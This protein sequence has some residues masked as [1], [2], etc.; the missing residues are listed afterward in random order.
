[1]LF[2]SST[3]VRSDIGAD[4][5][6]FEGQLTAQGENFRLMDNVK[7]MSRTNVVLA[8]GSKMSHY[9]SNSGNTSA[10]TTKIGS[11]AT[12]AKDSELG[13]G[14]DSYEVGYNGTDATYAGVLKAKTVTKQGA[15]IWTITNGGSTSAVTVSGGT[16]QLYNSPYSSSPTAFTSGSLV[17]NAGGTL[18]GIGCAGAV[19]IGRAH[20]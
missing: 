20:V 3:G 2:R 13:N 18:T 10:I 19:K 6:A 7:D 15:G 11:L 9:K 8:S 1:M 12:T 16:L 4:F 17:V 5:S 14:A